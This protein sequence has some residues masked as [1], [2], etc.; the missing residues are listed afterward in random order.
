MIVT[1]NLRVQFQTS[2][3]PEVIRPRTDSCYLTFKEMCVC[4]LQ[5][6]LVVRHHGI[7]STAVHPIQTS[8]GTCSFKTPG[9]LRCDISNFTNVRVNPKKPLNHP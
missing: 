2:D 5:I 4:M 1:R 6:E 3:G 7:H 9:C 8:P